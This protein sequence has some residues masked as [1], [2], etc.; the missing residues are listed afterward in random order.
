MEKD[1]Y[2]LKDSTYAINKHYDWIQKK[3][4][5]SKT[6]AIAFEEDQNFTV[7]YAGGNKATIFTIYAG[8]IITPEVAERF[9]REMIE[10][11]NIKKRNDAPCNL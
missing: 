10:Q 2:A 1:E 4:S 3:L 5:E 9:R 11:I 8:D 7:C 6:G